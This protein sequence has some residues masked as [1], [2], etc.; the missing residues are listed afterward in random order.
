ML[1]TLVIA[2]LLAAA[3][4]GCSSSSKKSTSTTTSTSSGSKSFQIQTPEGQVSLSLDGKLPPNW[5]SE[6]PVAPGAS[7]A[8]SGS[9]GNTS[10]TTLVGVYSTTGSAQD[11][12]NFYKSTSAYTV[13]SSSSA[14]IGSAF[15]GSVEFSGSYQGSA[16][17]ASLSGTTYIVI[18]L[19][20]GGASSTTT[21]TTGGT[22]TTTVAAT[23]TT[24]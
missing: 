20:T 11:A 10:K 21:T 12:F 19:E 8:G 9:L 13:D 23:T 24:I 7:P 2:L 6:F 16:T 3:A 18:V 4:V 14:G 22:T 15:V 1:R 17:I 5:P